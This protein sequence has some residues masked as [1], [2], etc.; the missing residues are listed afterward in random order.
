[1]TIAEYLKNPVQIRKAL[2]LLDE[3]CQELEFQELFKSFE[4]ELGIKYGEGFPVTI[5]WIG[6]SIC[7]ARINS[8]SFEL[9]TKVEQIGIKLKE[10][11]QGRANPL[12][13]AIFYGANNKSTAAYEVL[14]E[15]PN[16]DYVVTIGCWSPE[17][18]LKIVNLIDGED[19][20]FDKISFAH[21]L[22]KKYLEGWPELPR[23]SALLM[24][25][26]F[27]GK[28]KMPHYPGLYNITNV[29]AA[30][31]YSLQDVDGIGYAAVSN[32][33]EGFNI[34]IKDVSKLT[35]NTVERWLIRKHD[36]NKHEHKFLQ[37]GI[38]DDNGDIRW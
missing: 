13:H 5:I 20:D 16:D 3:Q 28:F 19:Q 29:I 36:Q 10:I 30:M 7:R 22:P 35:C 6:G 31:C 37:S 2:K 24:L 38:I 14:H 26:Y 23:K 21:S 15:E 4:K 18:E 27:K 32:K 34:A 8:P 12:Q 1:M 33:F 25:D 11:S 17:N 9:A